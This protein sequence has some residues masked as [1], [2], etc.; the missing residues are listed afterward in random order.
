MILEFTVS[1]PPVS[2]QSHNKKNLRAWQERVRAAAAK[3]WGS[4]EPLDVCLRLTVA[5]YHVGVSVRIDWDNCVKPIQDAL[6][7]L[8]YR[9]DRQITHAMVSKTSIS[10]FYQVPGGRSLAELRSFFEGDE[11][12]YVLIDHAPTDEKPNQ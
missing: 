7:G 5:Y 2:H 4:R 10:G 6:I 9:D 8:V 3:E 1:G 11:F 12:L